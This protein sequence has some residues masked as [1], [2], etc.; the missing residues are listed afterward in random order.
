MRT[1]V[2]VSTPP[3]ET[4]LTTIDRVKLELDLTDVD[5][6]RDNLL[7]Y[8][9]AEATSDIE[10]HLGRV[11]CRAG[12]TQTMWG[13]PGCAEY[14]ILDRY[15][16]ASIASVTIDD[17][18][19]ASSEYRLDA[20]TGLLYRLDASGYPSVWTWCK[21]AVIVFTAGYI[22]PGETNRDLPEA[23]EAGAV[24][25]VMSYWVSRGRDPLVRSEDIPG[26]GAV[27]YW[28]G[29]V[30]EAGQ[31]PPGVLSKIAPFRRVLM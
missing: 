18:A 26:L 22:M 12:L 6:S 2:T 4:D 9:I 11:L 8:K 27:Q 15:P 14:L 13:D 3:A 1:V 31:L 28:V 19:V 23:L 29:A 30:G 17:V 25:L 10:A 5:T 24:D 21:S 20:K 16:V 7:G